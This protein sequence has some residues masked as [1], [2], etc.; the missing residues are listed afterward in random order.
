MTR[1]MKGLLII[2]I[3]IIERQIIY[4]DTRIDEYGR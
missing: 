3:K 1:L 2:Y 4:E